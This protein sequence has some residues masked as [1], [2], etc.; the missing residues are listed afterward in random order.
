MP[1]TQRLEKR[2]W[3]STS[4]LD[5]DSILVDSL[6]GYVCTYGPHLKACQQLA[7][8]VAREIPLRSKVYRVD[9][10]NAAQDRFQKFLH[11]LDS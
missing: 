8:E 5:K 1:V 9:G 6:I 4:S 10:A 11:S 7:V 3:P 2:L